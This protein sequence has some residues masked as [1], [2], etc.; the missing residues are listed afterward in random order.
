M[1]N[2]LLDNNYK[3][4]SVILIVLPASGPAERDLATPSSPSARFVTSFL[5]FRLL[6][7]YVLKIN[8]FQ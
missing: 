1:C 8:Y 4:S 5:N 2:S 3:Y 7:D 6:T